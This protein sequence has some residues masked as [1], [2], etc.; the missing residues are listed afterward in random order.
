MPPQPEE[1]FLFDSFCAK[2]GAEVAGNEV[3]IVVT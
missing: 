3:L 2:L 1:V